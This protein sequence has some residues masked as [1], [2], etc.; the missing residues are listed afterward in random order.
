[1]TNTITHP[2]VKKYEEIFEIYTDLISRKKLSEIENLLFMGCYSD[3]E[4]RLKEFKSEDELLF[5]L[6]EKLRG[7]PIY[8]TLKRIR[9]GEVQSK[10]QLLKGLFSLGTHAMIEVEQGNGAYVYIAKRIHER[11]GKIL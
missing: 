7:K 1:M 6:E 11:I 2:A 4:E 10:A 8:S 3:C 5:M 9:K